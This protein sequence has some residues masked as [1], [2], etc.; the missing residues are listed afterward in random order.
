MLRKFIIILLNLVAF[1]GLSAS[2]S[3]AETT[4]PVSAIFVDIDGDGINDNNPDSNADGIPD[5]ATANLTAPTSEIASALGD[6]FA[7]ANTSIPSIV[8]YQTRC[9]RF[10][11]LK[12]GVRTLAQHRIGFI[13]ADQFGPGNGMG[14]SGASGGC[15]GGVCH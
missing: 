5:K 8:E 3:N 12:F 2:Y 15:A 14:A 6:Q 9:Q 13:S 4:L 11:A 7:L 10:A 1:G